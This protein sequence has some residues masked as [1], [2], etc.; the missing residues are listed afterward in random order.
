MLTI[1]PIIDESRKYPRYDSRD[2]RNVEL[3]LKLAKHVI[4]K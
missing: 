4:K 2:S 1:R 3:S